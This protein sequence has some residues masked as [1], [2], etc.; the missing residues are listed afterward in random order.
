MNKKRKEVK[1][2]DPTTQSAEMIPSMFNWI[3][4]DFQALRAEH[5]DKATKDG[6][7]KQ[8]IKELENLMGKQKINCNKIK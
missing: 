2:S 8:V 1:I 3:T 7:I 5:L 4:P 6:E